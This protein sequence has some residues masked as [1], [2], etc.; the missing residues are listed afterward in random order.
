MLFCLILVE[1]GISS[2]IL[3]KNFWIRPKINIYLNSLR[4]YPIRISH[5]IGLRSKI[6]IQDETRFV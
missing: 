5:G 6:T 1:G 3:C 2:V 4:F